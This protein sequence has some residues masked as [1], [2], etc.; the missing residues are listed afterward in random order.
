MSS[1]FLLQNFCD[2]IPRLILDDLYMLKEEEED[3][4]DEGERASKYTNG[5][6][7]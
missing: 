4:E 2:V 5:D 6:L 7:K 3:E 1:V